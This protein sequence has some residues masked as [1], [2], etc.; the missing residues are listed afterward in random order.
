LAPVRRGFFVVGILLF[1]AL[2]HCRQ[3]P[4]LDVLSFVSPP[5]SKLTGLL[6]FVTSH[7]KRKLTDRQT[8]RLGIV[9]KRK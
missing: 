1:G 4:C 9:T 7:P 6:S 3:T 8:H 5:D 2:T